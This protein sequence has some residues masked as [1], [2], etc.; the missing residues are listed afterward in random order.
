MF[1]TPRSVHTDAAL[2]NISIMHRN[3]KYLADRI[4]QTIM[5]KKQS[6]YFYKFPKGAWFRNDAR[7]RGPGGHAARGGYQILSDLYTCKEYAFAHPVPIE[8]I[9]NAD[10][11]IQPMATG[12]EFATNKIILKKEKLLSDLV[13]TASNWAS[14]ED[15]EGG[16]A[17]TVDGSGNTFIDDVLSA[18]ETIRKLIGV[19][20]NVMVL[21]AK[22]FKEVKQEY[23][24]LER[25]K[26][27]GTSG[28]PADVTAQT[29]AALFE[30][31]EVL[32]GTAIHSDAEETV[33]GTEFNAVDLWETNAGKGSCFL[34]YRPPSPGLEIPAAA[35]AFNWPSDVGQES[36]RLAGGG[37]IVRSVRYWWEDSPKQWVIEASEC[38]DIKVVSSDAGF[39]FYDTILT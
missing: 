13:C 26:Y 20:P 39:L 8:L 1:P 17:A 38:L 9:N 24:V 37:G 34:F 6:D 14:S 4:F 15:A 7:L 18:K 36:R 2:T 10:A 32:I 23:T 28:K 29:L 19:Y 35:Y 11:A 27:T 5:V 16:W 12:V 25:I 22:T 30:L 21:D 3:Q 33:A 31:D